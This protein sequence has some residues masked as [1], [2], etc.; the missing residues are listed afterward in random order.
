MYHMRLPWALK[1]MWFVVCPQGAVWRQ[2]Q[3]Q[4]PDIREQQASMEE[5]SEDPDA[6]WGPVMYGFKW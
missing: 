3:Q 1:Q 2:L 5:E 6:I 4:L